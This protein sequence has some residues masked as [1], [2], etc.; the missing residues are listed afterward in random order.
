M[1]SRVFS[2]PAWGRALA[3]P[4]LAA[5]LSAL[6]GAAPA[7]QPISCGTL[8]QVQRGDTLHSIAMQAYGNGNYLAIFDANRDLLPSAT[9]IEVGEQLLVPC[10]DGTGPQTRAEVVAAGAPA[11]QA[12]A[13]QAASGPAASA[14]AGSGQAAAQVAA[15][16]GN[17]AAAPPSASDLATALAAIPPDRAIRVLTGP[18]F[19]P[20]VDPSLPGGGLATQLVRLALEQAAFGRPYRIAIA[21][22]WTR[23]L[24]LL[25]QGDFDLG[26]PWYKPDCARAA[27][28]GPAM[29]RE[30][31]DFLF[32][33]PLF[34]V[35]MAWYVRAGDPL[36]KATDAQALVG[37]RLCRPATYFTFDLKEQGLVQPATT[38][39]FPKKPEDCFVLLQAG[40][41]DAVSLARVVA[42]P[43]IARLGLDGKV[44]EAP[45]LAS[46]E[47][48]HVIAPKSS[49]QART[50]LATFN[51][52]LAALKQSGRWF[53]VV[54]HQLGAFG[55]S[56]R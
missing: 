13:A 20:F 12:G 30:C 9:R 49:A 18:D 16:A 31:K 1:N 47:T 10:L 52:G 35:E 3:V 7:Q 53:E 25:A 40:V 43:E 48:L 51:A 28:L 27:S 8:Y 23:Q 55:V 2:L 22:D 15:Q 19:T 14:Q 38:L 44:A 46:V 34:D 54:S 32:S 4:L 39:V 42:G 37:H 41:V 21:S 36:A 6:A 29:Q 45:D 11:G 50:F 33:R 56:L 17:P 26:F 5:G 24:D